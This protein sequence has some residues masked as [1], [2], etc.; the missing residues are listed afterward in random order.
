MVQTTGKDRDTTDK[1]Y[2]KHHVVLQCLDSWKQHVSYKDTCVIE[3]S[4]GNGKFLTELVKI[5]DIQ[6]LSYDIHPEHPDILQQDFLETFFN[7]NLELHVIG[8][9]PFGRQSSTALKFI[10]HSC[11]F[12]SSFS[13]ILPRSFMKESLK[14]KVPPYFHCV[15]E[16]PLEQNSFELNGKD[17]DVPCVFQIWVKSSTKRTIPTKELPVGYSFV[18]KSDPHDISI[19]RVGVNCGDIHTITDEASVQSHYFIKFTRLP[20]LPSK[21]NIVENDFTVGPK[22]ISKQEV[23]KC[24]N[25]VI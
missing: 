22:S 24:L 9:P 25:E 12:A 21:L 13:F 23:I 5:P 17:Y 1:F 10:K 2:T 7:N 8:N 18:K 11:T 20:T 3:P 15:Y 4:A 19:R 6:L 14:S 16:H